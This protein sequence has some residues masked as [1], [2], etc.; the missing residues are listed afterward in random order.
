MPFPMHRRL[1]ACLAL[2]AAAATAACAS[3]LNLSARSLDEEGAAAPAEPSTV[4]EAIEQGDV[5]LKFRMRVETHDQSGISKDAHAQTLRTVLG[6]KSAPI[7]GYSAV[8]EFEDVSSLGSEHYNSTV[9]GR[10]DRPVIAD[11]DGTE[12]N[13]AYLQKDLG[14]GGQLRG[15][16]QRIILDNARFVGN[17]GWRQNEQTFDAFTAEGQPSEGVDVFYS[18]LTNVN[19]VFGDDSPMGDSRMKSHLLNVS[20]DVSETARVTGYWYYLDFSSGAVLRDSSTSTLGLRMA[21]EWND[22]EESPPFSASL[23]FAHQ[24]DI[25]N[26][27]THVNANYHHLVLGSQIGPVKI[28]AGHERLEGSSSNTANS[29]S[30]PLATLHAFNGW[31]DKFLTTP[32]GGLV[33]IYLA[34]GGKVEDT[35]LT[36]VLHDFH[37][38]ATSRDFGWEMDLAAVT[39]ID[40]SSSWGAKYADFHADDFATDSRKAWLWYETRF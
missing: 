39:P 6:F 36:A 22:D 35:K 12:L 1:L 29:F 32:G 13:Q 7:D 24:E 40:E 17:V 37:A 23:E 27:T 14:G 5:W 19:R 16:R 31:A 21:N 38:D 10:T 18:Y 20:T 8:I 26:N 9:N 11:P 3:P 25:S 15:G 4:R 28:Q 2:T 34:L 30:T 33:D